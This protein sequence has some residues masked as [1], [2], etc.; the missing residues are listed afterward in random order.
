MPSQK[1][2]RPSDENT[3]TTSANHSYKISSILTTTQNESSPLPNE[4]SI[5]SNLQ[6]SILN[7][8]CA[9]LNVTNFALFNCNETQPSIS[10]SFSPS[11]FV[12]KDQDHQRFIK[13]RNLIE[14][15]LKTLK[16][17]KYKSKNFKSRD[18]NIAHHK[19]SLP[20]SGPSLNSTVQENNRHVF[21]RP[22]LPKHIF[23]QGNH[24]TQAKN[25]YLFIP[26]TN[27]TYRNDSTTLSISHETENKQKSCQE[28]SK[29]QN[30]GFL[31]HRRPPDPQDNQKLVEFISTPLFVNDTSWTS[32]DILHTKLAL[33]APA[34]N[35][36]TYPI[37]ANQVSSS[38]FKFD[39]KYIFQNINDLPPLS[40]HRPSLLIFEAPFTPL[41]SI[42]IVNLN[43][44]DVTNLAGVHQVQFRSFDNNTKLVPDNISNENSSKISLKSETA[45]YY[46][47]LRPFTSDLPSIIYFHRSLPT[48]E[49]SIS[50]FLT[51]WKYWTLTVV[52]RLFAK[53]T[54]SSTL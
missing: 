34:T 5:N 14:K 26:D 7:T 50:L 11:A 38:S 37:G 49:L 21:V 9:N 48:R 28:L 1:K 35:L 36:I 19:S 29:F 44:F 33:Q 18:R 53:T 30:N 27:I 52:P 45:K 41:R 22:T 54:A 17:R 12:S 2:F 4:I 13:T 3:F 23:C 32:F 24:N 46:R 43:E 20:K 25:N 51:I 8:L 16:R 6:G 31:F 39:T 42:C 15:T 40:C 47:L 10:E